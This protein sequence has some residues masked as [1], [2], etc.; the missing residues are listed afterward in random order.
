MGSLTGAKPAKAASPVL[1]VDL[2]GTLI[3]GNVLWECV[4]ALLKTRP[5]TL[6]LLPFWLLSGRASV[7]RQVA[8]RVQFDPARL[9]YRQQVL[10]LLRK[11]KADGRRIVLATA[12]D[13]EIAVTVSSYLGLFDEVHASDG[14]L[15]FK[16][17]NKAAF[18]TQ[19]YSQTGFDYVGDSAADVEVWRS[20]RG[21]YVVGT[22]MRAEQAGAVTTLKA[23]IL[24]PRPSL[25]KAARTWINALR[26]HHWDGS[27]RGDRKMGGSHHARLALRR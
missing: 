17:A 6:L 20:A 26:G 15:N 9:L 8:A 24:E 4:L 21:A 16:G 5:G 25:W 23:T 19:T 3:R 14:Q 13:R 10:D 1:C 12:A 27:S 7:K 18:L 22:E 2:D 11:E